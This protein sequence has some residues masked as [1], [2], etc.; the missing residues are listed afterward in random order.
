MCAGQ[1]APS[2]GQ[3]GEHRSTG[4]G[5]R[6]TRAGGAGGGPAAHLP[7][8]GPDACVLSPSA[9]QD[10]WAARRLRTQQIPPQGPHQAAAVNPASR[11][12]PWCGQC[13][14]LLHTRRRSSA[15]PNQSHREEDLILH[16]NSSA[17]SEAP[18]ILYKAKLGRH[19]AIRSKMQV[20]TFCQYI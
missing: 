3:R 4:R 16:P 20:Y 7:S 2:S 12:A 18:I 8:D 1:D 13:P 6:S 19:K 10:G 15:P 9:C 17:D 5:P 14:R 11:R